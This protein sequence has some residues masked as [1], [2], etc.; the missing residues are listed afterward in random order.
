MAPIAAAEQLRSAALTDALGASDSAAE[1]LHCSATLSFVDSIP[2]PQDEFAPPIPALCDSGAPHPPETPAWSGAIPEAAST[3]DTDGLDLLLEEVTWLDGDGLEES[4]GARTDS[5]E[6]SRPAAAAPVQ[7]RAGRGSRFL[8][9]IVIGGGIVCLSLTGTSS[10]SR[11]ATRMGTPSMSSPTAPR[12]SRAEVAPAAGPDAPARTPLG[13]PTATGSVDDVQTDTPGQ[14]ALGRARQSGPRAA[15]SGSPAPAA[16]PR[17]DAPLP[18]LRVS[19]LYDENRL[20]AGHLLRR[21]GFG[22]SPA[23]LRLVLKK[24]QAAWIDRQLNP[25]K[26]GDAAAEAKL[27]H[28]PKKPD[29]DYDWIRRWYVRMAFSKRQLLEK[30]TLIWHE[31]FAT[32][33]QK[34]GYGLFMN[35]QEEFLRDNALGQFRDLLVGITEDQAMLI[36]LDNDNND[37]NS[38]D[39]PNENYA[40]E[41]LQLFTMGTIKLNLDGT[42]ELDGDGSVQAAYSETDV[43]EVARALTGWYVPYPRKSN[44]ARF[45]PYEHDAG[46]KT[47]MGAA[48]PGRSG[49]DGA[50]EVGDVVDLILQQRQTT[51]AAFISRTLIY[52][53]ATETPTPQYV[54]DVAMVFVNT[55]GNIKETVRAILTHPEFTDPAV[56]RTQYREPIEQFVGAVRGLGGFTDGDA[57]IDWSYDAGQLIY[58]PP[59]VFS[60]Y[61][62]G[63]KAVLQNT[64]YVFVRDQMA[65]EF[66]RPDSKTSFNAKRTVKK[67]KLATPEEV[68]DY[69]SDALLVAPMQDDVRAAVIAYMNG[70]VSEDTVRGA[71]WLI[72]CSPDYQRN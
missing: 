28:K 64:A 4:A 34:V 10:L 32:S 53:L 58:Y 11:A 20:L 14:A 47:I 48:L 31:H 39:P 26:I 61:P 63:N 3:S 43:K 23:D 71:A 65:D 67:Q 13:P 40:R 50:N 22:A 55:N 24:G 33:N 37:G 68:V 27:P 1:A 30:M 70:V 52:K 12:S 16:L 69:L 18:P 17:G 5:G 19:A 15:D 9:S 35:D 25:S 29:E 51:I 62:P 7:P 72:L 46:P 36:W 57:L 49:A 2:H 6:A 60:F 21:A 42:P 38:E 44:N 54:S 41:F 45:A 66:A 59:S 8:R 56:V